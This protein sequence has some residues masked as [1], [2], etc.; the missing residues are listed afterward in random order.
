M[1]TSMFETKYFAYKS[2]R[3]LMVLTILVTEIQFLST[4]ASGKSN[5]GSSI[6]EI[7]M[8]VTNITVTERRKLSSTSLKW[9]FFDIFIVN[10]LTFSNE[11]KQITIK[12]P[13]TII[14]TRCDILSRI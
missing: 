8:F 10:L 13:I 2:R 5:V 4:L 6:H 11:D 12:W 3:W 1:V 7:L 14:E 9:K